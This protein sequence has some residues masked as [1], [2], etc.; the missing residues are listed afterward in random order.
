MVI[1]MKNPQKLHL[2]H[3]N[4]M[5]TQRSKL[6]EEEED[7]EEVGEG[8]GEGE[9]GCRIEGIKIRFLPSK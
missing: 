1:Y 2:H 5:Q 3:T 6:E 4:C 8:Q 9:E 7:D